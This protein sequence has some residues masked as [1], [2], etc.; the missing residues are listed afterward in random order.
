MVDFRILSYTSSLLYI[1]SVRSRLVA[2]FLRSEEAATACDLVSLN[3]SAK[4]LQSEASLDL[5]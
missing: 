3:S 5:A 4:F 1:Y 2:L